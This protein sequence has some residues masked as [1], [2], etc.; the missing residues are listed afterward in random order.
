M[1][2]EPQQRGRVESRRL[3]AAARPKAVEA[4]AAASPR[5]LPAQLASLV[6]DQLAF[7]RGFIAHPE[8]VGSVWPSSSFLERRLVRAAQ[9]EQARTLVELGPGTGGTTRALLA[10]M[11]PDARLL[12]IELNPEFHAR[13][14]ARL[15]DP[16]LIV[17]LGSAEELPELLQRWRLPAPEVILS[18]IPFSTMPKESAERIA[19][20]IAHCLAPG[21]RFV[22]Y[23][24]RGHVARF[25]APHLGAPLIRWEMVN[26]P[27]LRVFRWVKPG[28]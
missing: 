13:L 12:A 1:H 3:G 11:R 8:Q 10:A 21:G 22:A 17:Q 18:G 25:L 5:P 7:L 27:P 6:S 19:A 14:R 2:P 20:A 9:A 4:V 28:P 15:D 23:Q 26:V 24:V 16:R